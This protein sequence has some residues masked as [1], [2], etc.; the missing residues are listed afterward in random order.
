MLRAVKNGESSADEA[1]K[2]LERARPWV[3]TVID[4]ESPLLLATASGPRTLAM[5]Q[6]VVHQGVQV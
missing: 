2:R 4:P 6:R 1:L 5:A 3:G